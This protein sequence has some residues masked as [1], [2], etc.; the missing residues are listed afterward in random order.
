MG[1]IVFDSFVLHIIQTLEEMK[2]GQLPD[3]QGV[4]WGFAEYV[5]VISGPRRSRLHAANPV[6]RLPLVSALQAKYRKPTLKRLKMKGCH[7]RQHISETSE[8][9]KLDMV[10]IL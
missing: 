2:E 7:W 8:G 5:W 9:Q 10:F 4:E 1:I 3:D 6:R